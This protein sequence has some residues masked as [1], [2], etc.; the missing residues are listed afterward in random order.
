MPSPPEQQLVR[1]DVANEC[2]EIAA[3]PTSP[4]TT[5]I[6]RA[7]AGEAARRRERAVAPVEQQPVALVANECV[8]IAVA[9]H[10]AKT[11]ELVRAAAGEAARRRERIGLPS[12]APD[13]SSPLR[14]AAVG[15]RTPGSP[16][17]RLAASSCQWAIERSA[18]PSRH[19]SSRLRQVH[20]S[21]GSATRD[22][23]AVG[24]TR[25]GGS[26]A[27]Q[28]LRGGGK[29]REAPGR[30]SR[31]APVSEA[32][33]GALVAPRTRLE[34]SASNPSSPVRTRC[35][36]ACCCRG[37]GTR[38]CDAQKKHLGET[39]RDPPGRRDLYRPLPSPP[40]G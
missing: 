5:D 40:R 28:D 16:C 17:T 19:H 22:D 25:G 11:T 27:W 24:W 18:V 26:T 31:A 37:V 21:R 2:V 39:L 10:I 4:K 32:T 7:A 6:V 34:A 20:A 8:E 14:M 12:T 30:A 13:S 36:G 29:R 33:P 1:A 38:D 3:P 9:V 35:C 23:G 15:R